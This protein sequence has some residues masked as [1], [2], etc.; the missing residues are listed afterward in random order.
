MNNRVLRHTLRWI[1]LLVIDIFLVSKLE[2]SIYVHPHIYL[3][4]IVLLPVRIHRSLLLLLAFATGLVMDMFSNTG[5]LFAASATF[6]AFTRI[7]ALPLFISAEDYEN[8]AEP[9]PHQLGIRSFLFYVSILVLVHNL[10]FFSLEI[11]KAEYAG[12]ILLKSMGSSIVTILLLTIIPWV[13]RRKN[14]ST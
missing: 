14:S 6:M 7:F 2:L 8:N 5:G 1:A 4:F 9:G 10:I 13:F 11:F 3:L 12:L